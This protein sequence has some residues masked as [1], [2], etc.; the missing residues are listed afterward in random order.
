MI[1]AVVEA[2][3]LQVQP[4]PQTW[5]TY[6]KSKSLKISEKEEKWLFP[7][8]SEILKSGSNGVFV[9]FLDPQTC[10]ATDP[11]TQK[12]NLSKSQKKEEKVIISTYVFFFRFLSTI[13]RKIHCCGNNLTHRPEPLI[14]LNTHR[15]G[16]VI[17]WLGANYLEKKTLL[18]Q[19]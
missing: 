6:T 12:A 3:L 9:N 5:S 17:Q 18:W 4:D 1:A 14:H 7:I 10:Q 13:L 15:R 19:Q 16:K 2:S 8:R 11:L